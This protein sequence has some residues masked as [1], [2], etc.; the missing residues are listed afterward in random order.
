MLPTA[1]KLTA[2]LQKILNAAAKL[3]IE[4]LAVEDDAGSDVDREELAEQLGQNPRSMANNLPKLRDAGLLIVSPKTVKV[5]EKG[6]K[7]AD[8]KNVKSSAPQTN[9]ELQQRLMEK[10][11]LS[12][13]EKKVLNALIDGSEKTKESVAAKLGMQIRSFS[14]NLTKPKKHGLLEVNGKNIRL[15]DKMFVK[16][17]GRP[18]DN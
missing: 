10:C 15:S 7:L 16:K 3:T 13:S 6:M 14:N 17:I 2:S 11:K 5:T 9:A 1:T 4:K 8:T 12:G 18:C